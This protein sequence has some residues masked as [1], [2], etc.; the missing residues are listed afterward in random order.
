MKN[1]PGATK[2]QQRSHTVVTLRTRECPRITFEGVIDDHS[3][4]SGGITRGRDVR[5]PAP[6][7]VARM[8]TLTEAFGAPTSLY[9]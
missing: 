2:V 8:S 7:R 6:G 4:T 1:T 9:I 5:P 3:N